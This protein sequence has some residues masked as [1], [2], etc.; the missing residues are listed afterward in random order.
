MPFQ[1]VCI[2]CSKQVEARV[3]HAKRCSECSLKRHQQGSSDNRK[4]S[5]LKRRAKKRHEKVVNNRYWGID[6]EG[7]NR[8][9]VHDYVYM[10]AVCVENEQVVGQQYLY[11]K[12]QRRL[13]TDECLWFLWKLGRKGDKF[14]FYSSKYDWTKILGDIEPEILDKI[15]TPEKPFEVHWWNGWGITHINNVVTLYRGKSQKLYSDVWRCLNQGAFIDVI[16]QWKAPTE[17]EQRFVEK[18]KANRGSFTALTQEIVDYCLL[19]CKL[20][21]VVFSR[22][23]TAASEINIRP[24]KLYSAGS[25]AKKLMRNNNVQDYRGVDRYAGAPE[26]LKPHILRGYV[27]GRFELTQIGEFE[28]LYEFDLKSAYPAAMTELPCLAHGQW[29][30]GEHSQY[31]LQLAT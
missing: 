30:H 27:G 3:R 21:A 19:E 10:A 11:Y 25:F 22:M 26:E 20:L 4:R 15:F 29:K 1:I 17:E 8:D 6:G 7:I 13:T 18:M 12:D 28:Q 5:E 14:A 16:D 31:C 9:G 2:D 24:N 23:M